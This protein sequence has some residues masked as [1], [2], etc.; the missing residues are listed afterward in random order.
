MSA[1][2]LLQAAAVARLRASPALAGTGV[3]DA[4]PVRAALPYALVDEPLLADWSTKSWTGR[5]AR[6][7]VLVHDAGER[8][9][10][11]RSL[12]AAAEEAL[13]SLG[14]D[15][16]GDRGGELADGW[17]IAGV[18]LLRNRIVRGGERWIAGIE[19]RVRVYRM[20]EE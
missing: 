12:A 13:L 11:L 18:A 3:F 19:V 4:P 2:A 1:A 5:E 10:R 8:P 17:R 15:R 20:V 14:G 16:G 9:V 7:S 6:L